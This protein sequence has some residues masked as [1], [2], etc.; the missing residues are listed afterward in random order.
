MNKFILA[1][2][3]LLSGYVLYHL[4]AMMVLPNAGSILERRY[5]FLFYPYANTILLNTSWQFFSP[6]PSSS[7]YLQYELVI[8]S[9]EADYKTYFWPPESSDGLFFENYN[10]RVYHSLLTTFTPDLTQRF[11]IDY[12]CRKHAQAQSIVLYQMNRVLPS[13]ER[14]EVDQLSG[15]EPMRSEVETPSFEYDCERG[16]NDS[17]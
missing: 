4:A 9:A 6:N 15:F 8:D 10:R 2:K 17:L 3:I 14:A 11:L 16:V 5:G 13:I 1:A 12:L 7:R